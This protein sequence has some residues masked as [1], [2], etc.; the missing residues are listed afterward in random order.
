MKI[1]NLQTVV[2][3]VVTIDDGSQVFIYVDLKERRVY[4]PCS[5]SADLIPDLAEFEEQV[6]AEFSSDHVQPQIPKPPPHVVDRISALRSDSELSY[7]E[8]KKR[9]NANER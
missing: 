3:A 2:T 6:L 4:L 8:A 1:T 9:I 5:K 7:E